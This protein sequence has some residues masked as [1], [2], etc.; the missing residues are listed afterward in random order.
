MTKA[1]LLVPTNGTRLHVKDYGGAGPPLMML[2]ATGFGW[3]Q[4]DAVAEE[5]AT[6]YHSYAVDLR[7]HGDSDKPQE[8]YAVENLAA[9]IQ[10]LLDALGIGHAFATGHSVGAKTVIAHASLYPDRFTKALI[11]EPVV[12]PPGVERDTS[13]IVAQARRRRPS[14]PS[15]EAMFESYRGRSPFATWQPDVLRLYCEEGTVARDGSCY[16]KCTPELEALTL[17][18]S[19]QFDVWRHLPR[20]NIPTRF[21]WSDQRWGSGRDAVPG[22]LPQS[23]AR[24][25]PGTSHTLVME[26]PKAVATE[27]V[28]FFGN[29]FS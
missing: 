27:A 6:V 19:A 3:W 21:V 26:V 18:A 10:G 8:G 28:E 17:L 1:S 2:H 29:G 22:V 25:I 11:I 14:F 12:N 13:Q 24:T 15:P 4:W 9:D 7:G 16:L 20:V 23:E 5:L